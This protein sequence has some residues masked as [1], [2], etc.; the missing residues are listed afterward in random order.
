MENCRI[1]EYWEPI[2][3]KGAK[4]TLGHALMLAKNNG[5]KQLFDKWGIE[6]TSLYLRSITCL[7][8]GWE[9]RADGIFY[10]GKK[11]FAFT[12][13][14]ADTCEPLDEYLFSVAIGE[15][16]PDFRPTLWISKD[17][18][19]T[20][21]EAVAFLKKIGVNYVIVE[22]VSTPITEEILQNA[23]GDE[24]FNI[25]QDS[26]SRQ[27]HDVTGKA[28]GIC[29]VLLEYD[30]KP[31]REAYFARQRRGVTEKYFE[32]KRKERESFIAEGF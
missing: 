29:K 20:I 27:V 7:D 22:G 24:Y 19:F 4:D 13:A 14:D 10:Y 18:G 9:C 32:R 26:I 6:V 8:E 21:P 11:V 2:P 23:V 12:S 3:E 30:W 16:R 17:S 28:S 25:T 31:I 15:A 5:H 1:R